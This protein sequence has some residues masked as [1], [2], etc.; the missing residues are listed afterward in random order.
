[1]ELKAG[2]FMRRFLLHV[3]PKGLMRIRHYGLPANAVVDDLIPRCRKL[4]GVETINPSD[5]EAP[6]ERET[7]QE[8]TQRLT[9]KDVTLCPECRAGHLIVKEMLFA[10]RLWPPLQPGSR[11]P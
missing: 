9:G 2:E 5:T 11:S 1:M 8:L 10:L 6:E 4:L 3:V 7:W